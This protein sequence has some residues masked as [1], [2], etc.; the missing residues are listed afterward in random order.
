[1]G[2]TQHQ[3]F[4]NPAITWEYFPNPCYDPQGKWGGCPA[5]LLA[6]L[7]DERI[8]AEDRIWAFA[9]CTALPDRAKRL[10]AVRCVRE[11]PIGDGRTVAD[12]LTDPRSLAALEV[13]EH[14][15]L[16]QATDGELAAARD[17]AWGVARDAAWGAARAAAWDAARDA[18]WD[19]ARKSQVEISKSMFA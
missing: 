16:G 18:A 15:A 10:F 5:D 2:H 11:T 12:L 8:P 6:L 13:V 9:K 3:K 7:G 14:H 19:A 4:E 17:A 1:M